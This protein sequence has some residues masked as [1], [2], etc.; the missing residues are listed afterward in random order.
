MLHVSRRASSPGPLLAAAFALLLGAGGAAR[1][2]APEPVCKDG[3]KE[4]TADGKFKSCYLAQDF[5]VGPYACRASFK[6]ALHPSGALKECRLVKPAQVSGVT[7]KDSLELYEDGKLR[8]AVVEDTKAFG[9]VEARPNDFVTLLPSGKL[10]RLE[11]TGGMRTVKGFPCKGNHIYFH[12]NGALRKVQLSEPFKVD[13][14][15]LPKDT[16]LCWDATGKRV[17]P[18]GPM[19]M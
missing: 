2:A 9:D 12:E 5:A 4:T 11:L 1:A 17:E 13:G 8:R 6:L 16:F 19:T 14:K 10:S 3:K 18:C 7:V 15:E